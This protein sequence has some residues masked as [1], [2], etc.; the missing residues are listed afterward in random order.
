MGIL[1]WILL[2]LVAGVLANFIMPGK[3]SGGWIMT[4]LLGIAGAFFGGWVGG[5]F[6]IG[7]VG[8]LSLPSLATATGGAVLLLFIYRLV[9]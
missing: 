6:G 4:I 9:K 8:S 1:S 5:F 7:S 2:G 3:G